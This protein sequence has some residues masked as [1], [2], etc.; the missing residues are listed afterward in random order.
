MEKELV[1]ACRPTL[2]LEKLCY[3]RLIVNLSRNVASSV[4]AS[5]MMQLLAVATA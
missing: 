5:N 4:K 1:H 3:S 2:T